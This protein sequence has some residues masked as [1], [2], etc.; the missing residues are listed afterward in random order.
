LPAGLRP[1][2]S[3]D[4]LAQALTEGCFLLLPMLA[5]RRAALDRVGHFDPGLRQAEDWD[6]LLRL[7][8]SGARFLSV[9]RILV[10]KRLRGDSLT[11]DPE[12]V[13]RWSLDALSKAVARIPAGSPH[14]AL[15]TRM[16]ATLLLRASANLWR[17]GARDPAVRR[18]AEALEAWPTALHRPEVHLGI[19]IRLLPPWQR[20]EGEVLRALD[21]RA[22]EVIA[23][24]DATL[25]YVRARGR[26]T[27]GRRRPLATVHAVLAAL[28]A[29]RGAWSAAL[30]H[31]AQALAGDPLAL[32][33]LALHVLTRRRSRGTPPPGGHLLTPTA[34]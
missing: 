16:R 14:R 11:A 2:L 15:A 12:Q 22:G 18:C 17:V 31:G 5:V 32:S 4:S 7:A 34:P 26:G 25:A 20:T 29:R 9:E 28:F 13:L 23:L 8:A 10:R 19:L 3:A 33:G 30:R 6:L 1:R 21:S 24:V 27:P